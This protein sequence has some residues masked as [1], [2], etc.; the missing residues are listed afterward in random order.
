MPEL[1]QAYLLIGAL[2]SAVTVNGRV[3]AKRSIVF[4]E[5][6]ADSTWSDARKMGIMIG[7]AAAMTVLWFPFMVVAFI[8]GFVSAAVSHWR[9]K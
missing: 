6:H 4:F 7:A 1:W 8:A 3:F 5:E 2:I 9:E